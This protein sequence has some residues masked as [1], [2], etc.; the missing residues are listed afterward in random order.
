MPSPSSIWLE[1]GSR[2]PTSSREAVLEAADELGLG[3]PSSAAME[4]SPEVTRPGVQQSTP[5]CSPQHCSIS[6]GNDD[7]SSE[8]TPE[9]PSDLEFMYAF[10]QA[11]PGLEVHCLGTQQRLGGG[12]TAARATSGAAAPAGAES[13]PSCARGA[14]RK[15]AAPSASSSTSA[16]RRGEGAGGNARACLDFLSEPQLPRSAAAKEPQRGAGVG[17]TGF[18]GFRS[19]RSL[20]TALPAAPPPLRPEASARRKASAV[21]R[22]GTPVPTGKAVSGGRRHAPDWAERPPSSKAAGAAPGASP[23]KGA[24]AAPLFDTSTLYRS[25]GAGPVNRRNAP[26]AQGTLLFAPVQPG[27]RVSGAPL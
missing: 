5:E 12:E 8:S 14:H 4:A 18:G 17:G 1:R 23:K 19:P 10:G 20:A 25:K 3:G 11:S 26:D 7:T 6:G 27:D 16:P 2:T 21:D 13:S 9:S 15:A 22:A 24:S